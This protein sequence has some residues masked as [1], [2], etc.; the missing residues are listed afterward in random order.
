VPLGAAVATPVSE[1]DEEDNDDRINYFAS[2]KAAQ[3]ELVKV[4]LLLAQS[5]TVLSS[6]ATQIDSLRS[7]VDVLNSKL[8]ELGYSEYDPSEGEGLDKDGIF[9]FCFW[10]YI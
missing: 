9:I 3:S 5:Q 2:Y 1:S 7:E 10:C 6:Q 4:N 8:S